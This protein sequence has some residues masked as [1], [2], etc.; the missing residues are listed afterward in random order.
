MTLLFDSSHSR[1]VS[2][3]DIKVSTAM[4]DA[5]LVASGSVTSKNLNSFKSTIGAMQHGEL[6]YTRF[7]QDVLACN[8]NMNLVLYT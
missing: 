4:I 2:S 8:V 5:M 1:Q 7:Y 3:E 6:L